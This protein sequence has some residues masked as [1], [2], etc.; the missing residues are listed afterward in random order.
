MDK[1]VSQLTVFFEGPFW[2][3]VYERE[4]D[5]KLEI[6]KL[7]FGAEPKDSEVWYFLLG[8]WRRLK[9]SPAIEAESLKMAQRN[10]KQMQRD[11]GKRLQS[12]GVGTKAQQA[13]KLQQEEGKLARKTRSREAR[14]A[15]A[16]RRFALKTEKRKEKHRGR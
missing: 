11:A 1:A 6:C 7:T 14:E 2:V 8:N 15:E 16:E 4:A 5:G 3:G 10:T 13:L 9:F 12:V